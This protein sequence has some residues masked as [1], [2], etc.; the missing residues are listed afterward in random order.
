MS[1]RLLNIITASILV[2]IVGLAILAGHQCVSERERLRADGC[3]VVET[4]LESAGQTCAQTGT[5][6]SCST[7]M[8]TIETWKC[9][10]GTTIER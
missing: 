5:V 1:E 9:P 3:E 4:R 10:D 6:F 7:H 8:R 2:A